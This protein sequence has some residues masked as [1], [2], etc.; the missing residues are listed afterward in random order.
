MATPVYHITHSRNLSSIVSSQS[1]LSNRRLQ[2]EGIQCRSIAHISIQDNRS[3]T[4]VPC[5]PGGD[6]HDY[7]PF[8]FAPL[9][10]TI[11]LLEYFLFLRV[12]NPF[13]AFPHGVTGCGDPCGAAWVSRLGAPPQAGSRLKPLPHIHVLRQ[14]DR[15][16][17]DRPRTTLGKLLI[18]LTPGEAH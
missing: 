18:D 5:G 1:L 4:Q 12:F 11:Y 6:I 7:V 13:V 16:M 2:Q 10:L 15:F 3:T 8:Y 14:P 9:L 17:P